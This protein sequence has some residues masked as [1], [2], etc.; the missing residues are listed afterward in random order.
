MKNCS[1]I[2]CDVSY[3]APYG[4]KPSNMFEKVDGIIRNY[5]WTNYLTFFGSEKYI[6]I[7]NRI[8]IQI[9]F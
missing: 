4:L 3:K 8:L 5:D 9:K 2:S 1:K 6:S 7:V